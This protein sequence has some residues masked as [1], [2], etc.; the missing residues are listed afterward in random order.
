[1]VDS[2]WQVYLINETMRKELKFIRQAL[3][4]NF[5]IPFEVPIA[6]IIPRTLTA[7]L[8]GDISCGNYSSDLRFW[9]FI[10]FPDK[11]VAIMLLHLKYNNNQN[12]ISINDRNYK[13]LGHTDGQHG[14]WVHWRTQLCIALLI[15]LAPRIG[16]CTPAKSL[17]S[18]TIWAVSFV[19][20]WLD[21][22]LELMLNGSA[23]WPTRLQMIFQDSRK[24]HLN[25]NIIL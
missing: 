12:F 4:E 24:S 19:N 9:W 15:K 21:Q 18:N 6:F 10:P 11:I 7:L 25:Y 16:Q 22:K 23:R 3:Q 14:R 8:F 5:T 17:S 2:H 1:M 13:L 20:F